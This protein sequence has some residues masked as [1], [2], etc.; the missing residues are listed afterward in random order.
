MC[1]VSVNT[2]DISNRLFLFH[3]P[4]RLFKKVFRSFVA[5]LEL[6]ISNCDIRWFCKISLMKIGLFGQKK[7]T[8]KADH[9]KKKKRV[10]T[11]CVTIFFH[12]QK[13]VYCKSFYWSKKIFVTRGVKVLFFRISQHWCLENG[14][15]L[16]FK[17]I[18]LET[19]KLEVCKK[20]LVFFM[21]IML[22]WFQIFFERPFGS[23]LI[24]YRCYY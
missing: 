18:P 9:F 2:F 22:Y 5:L 24:V 6:E 7:Q 3:P 16:I 19:V 21:F 4:R 15:I 20:S 11:P 12:H 13:K 17:A 8:L 10:F 14:I 1:L 23:W